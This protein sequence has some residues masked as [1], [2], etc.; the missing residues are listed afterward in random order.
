MLPCIGNICTDKPV[1]TLIRTISVWSP[2]GSISRSTFTT[3]SFITFSQK[4]REKEDK[5]GYIFLSWTAVIYAGSQCSADIWLCCSEPVN[6]IHAD[7]LC[8]QMN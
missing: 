5:F 4:N 6:K 2:P 3:Q 8:E 1:L 7:G